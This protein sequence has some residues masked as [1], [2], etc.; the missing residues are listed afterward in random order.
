VEEPGAEERT[1]GIEVKA[2]SLCTRCGPAFEVREW[3]F[4]GVVEG[5]HGGFICCR[6]CYLQ[7]VAEEAEE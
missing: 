1:L 5:L 4:V 7:E 6:E 3:L 2:G